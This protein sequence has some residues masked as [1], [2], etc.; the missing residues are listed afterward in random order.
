MSTK[1]IF[2]IALSVL[3]TIFLM[4]NTDAVNFNFIVTTKPVSKLTVIGVCMVVGFILGYIVGKP[5]ITRSSYDNEF[6]ENQSSDKP[7][8]LLS[9]E[10]R[11]Y[12][13]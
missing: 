1:S 5:K 3:L 11:D 8:N 7:K 9:D 4:S 2:I 6:E 13:S 12:I 10:D